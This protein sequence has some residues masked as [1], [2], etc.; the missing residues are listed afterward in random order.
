MQNVHFPNNAVCGRLFVRDSTFADYLST[1]C[2]MQ[3]GSKKR[4]KIKDGS[5]FCQAQKI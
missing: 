4:Y 5:C 2:H 1:A 3:K